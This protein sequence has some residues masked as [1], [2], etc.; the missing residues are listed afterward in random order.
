M[1][2]RRWGFRCGKGGGRVGME[3]TERGICFRKAFLGLICK[4]CQYDKV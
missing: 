4:S 1:G 2:E 3:C